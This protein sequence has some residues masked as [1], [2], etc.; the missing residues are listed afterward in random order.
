ML[1]NMSDSNR[2]RP[3]CHWISSLSSRKIEDRCAIALV[4]KES[5]TYYG[6]GG[7]MNEQL[8][9]LDRQ[10]VRYL[11]NAPRATYAE[12]AR[13]TGVSETTVRRRMD[14]LIKARV[15]TPAVIPD[16]RQLGYR[17]MALVGINVDLNHIY[18][19]VE[20]IRDLPEVTSLHMTM[21]RY[22]LFATIAAPDLDSLMSVLIHKIA[23]L[24]GVRDTESFVSTRAVKILRDWRLPAG[25]PSLAE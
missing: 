21:G 3:E 18:Q 4:M 1:V 20:H 2:A 14:A 19:V 24:P 11:L 9:E 10:I 6:L 15:I 23:P 7:I 5:F 12:V 13:A 8:D 17:A 22:D 16:V 25:E